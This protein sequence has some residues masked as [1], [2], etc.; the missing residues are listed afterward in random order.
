[1]SCQETS[2]RSQRAKAFIG[3]NGSKLVFGAVAVAATGVTIVLGKK[4][5][6]LKRVA[7]CLDSENTRLIA[8]KI[9][10]KALCEEKDFWTT[11]LA[12]DATRLGSSLGGKILNDRKLHL[13]EISRAA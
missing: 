6:D 10:L 7:E 1:M 12:A 5:V 13:D 8:D 11:S 3:R 9:A 4:C 2:T